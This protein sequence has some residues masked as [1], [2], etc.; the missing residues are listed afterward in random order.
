MDVLLT[1]LVPVVG[2]RDVTEG[3]AY[4]LFWDCV[5]NDVPI[6]EDVLLSTDGGDAYHQYWQQADA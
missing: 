5:E 3:D 4:E 1:T 2:D 6:E